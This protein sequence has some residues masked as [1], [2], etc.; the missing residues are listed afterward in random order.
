MIHPSPE[1]TMA[2]ADLASELANAV[3]LGEGQDR[4]TLEAEMTKRLAAFAQSILEQAKRPLGETA[5]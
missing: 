1:V 2:A 5:K 3:G 4:L